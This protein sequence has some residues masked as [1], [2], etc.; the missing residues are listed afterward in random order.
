MR[1]ARYVSLIPWTLQSGSE[2]EV[3]L[4]GASAEEKF[5]FQTDAISKRLK[6][7]Q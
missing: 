7:V 1:E 5:Y 4:Q 6:C 2:Q 3:F